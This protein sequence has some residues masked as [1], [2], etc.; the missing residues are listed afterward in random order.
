[1]TAAA[2]RFFA[3]APQGVA[4]VLREELGSLGALNAREAP[5]GVSFEGTLELAYRLCLWSRTANRVL[6][7]LAEFPA[8]TPEALYDGIKQLPWEE[9]LNS[10]GTLAVD[11]NASASRITHTHFGAQRVKDAIVDRFRE[12]SGIR[13]SVDTR[14]PDL[15]VNLYLR[16]DQASVS[17]DLS[18]ESL[19]RRGYRR[20]G[21]AAPL[22]EN[23][24]AA[25]LLRAAW[26]EV[27][28]RGGMLLDPMC[29]SG[30]LVVEAAL[31]A[32]DIAPGLLRNY[33]GF[34]GWLGHAPALWGKLLDEARERR[35]LGLAGIPPIAGYDASPQAVQAARANV[36]AAGLHALVRVEQRELSALVRPAAE[37]GLVMVNPPYGER[38]GDAD[39]LVPLYAELGRR[40]R[41]SFKGWRAAVFTGNPDLARNMGLRAR[42]LHPF[43][44]G[45]IPCKLL[46]F[47]VEPRWYTGGD[48]GDSASGRAAV[49][50]GTGAAGNMFANRLGKNLKHLGRWARRE[51]IACYRLYDA[52]MPEYA[53]AVDLYRGER[54]WVHVQ[55]YAAPASVGPDQARRRLHEALR[56]LPRVLDVPA[57]QV[58]FK[59]RRRQRGTTQY[60]KLAEAGRFHQVE[61][62]GCR[63]L[64]NFTDYLDTGL[65]LDHRPIRALIRELAG[66]TRFLN[67]FAYTGTASVY[68]ASGGAASTTS[69]DLSATYLEWARRNLH[70]NGFRGPRHD[71]IQADCLAWLSREAAAASRRFDLIFLDPPTFSSSKRMQANL[72]VQRDH[73]DLIRKSAVLLE[74]GGILI[75]SNNFRRFRMDR[76]ALS[77]LQVQDITASTIPQDFSRSPRIHNCWRIARG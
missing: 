31:M 70:L 38:L 45:A 77:G 43:Y 56:E 64:V 65:F 5:A 49:E 63:F 27:A 15:R 16:R 23:L 44:N 30:T 24:A 39:R 25:I 69:V 8:A 68:A 21:V 53:L 58:F 76:E 7:P 57:E 50:G 60:Q 12:A 26:P 13:P 6:L 17:L 33:F 32:G 29:G 37:P 18:G 55:E 4:P 22:K 52:D 75:F 10:S 67:L 2:R 46:R 74:P 9:H 61:E 14:H 71:L 20:A 36:D 35:S 66:G 34:L 73:V 42:R 47:E 1:M 41:E 59:V 28:A 54:L 72:D 40:L 51:G 62:G 11:F 19:H 48:L 3:T